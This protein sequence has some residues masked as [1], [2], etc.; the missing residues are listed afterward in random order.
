VR[1]KRWRYVLETPD[2]FR[3]TVLDIPKYDFNWQTYYIF[4]SPLQVPRGAKL[5]ATAWYDNSAGNPSNP[6]PKMEVR[7]GD[8][9]WDEMHYTGIL[10]S[11][12]K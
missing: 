2:G 9:V 6:D 4:T 5:I 1:G 7:W 8:Q 3:R 12:G 11:P 10:V